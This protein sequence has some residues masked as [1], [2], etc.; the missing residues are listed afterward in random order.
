M[1]QEKSQQE[2]VQL[3][4]QLFAKGAKIELKRLVNTIMVMRRQPT[5][6][7]RWIGDMVWWTVWYDMI[8]INCEDLFLIAEH[9]VSYDDYCERYRDTENKINLKTFIMSRKDG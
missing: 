6:D 3:V 4:M 9:K 2:Y 1:D 7:W 5:D 8:T